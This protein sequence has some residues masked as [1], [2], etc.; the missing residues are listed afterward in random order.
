MLGSEHRLRQMVAR[1]LNPRG[2]SSPVT[3]SAWLSATPKRVLA[4]MEEHR[5]TWQMWHVRAEAQRQVRDANVPPAQSGR[6]V[7]LLVAE[8]LA[9][10]VKLAAPEDGV[11]EPDVLCRRDGSSVYTV[12]G[13][14]QYTSQRVLDAEQRLL[15][16]AARH[17]GAV[18]DESAVD[19]ALLEMTANGTPLDLG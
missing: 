7:D 18:V 8:V 10:S 1:A 19:V 3:D 2:A 9:L 15:A 13:G 11:V 16:A 4:I 14:D 17:E 5:S 12:A 6:V